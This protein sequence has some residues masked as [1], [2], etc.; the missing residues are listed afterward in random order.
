MKQLTVGIDFCLANTLN[1]AAYCQETMKFD[2]DLQGYLRKKEGYPAKKYGLLVDLNPYGDTL[3]SLKEISDLVK[4]C[5]ALIS[6]Y[7][8]SGPDSS[9]GERVAAEIVAFAKELKA[10]CQ[11]ARQQNKR[12]CAVSD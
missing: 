5:E 10:L 11:E 2:E 1:E 3:F 6:E 7:G 8:F 9:E 12:V 4:V